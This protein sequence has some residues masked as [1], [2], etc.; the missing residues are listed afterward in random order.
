MNTVTAPPNRL[1]EIRESLGLSLND[2]ASLTG[3][4]PSTISRHE[5]GS[6]GLHS[7]ML[8]LYAERYSINKIEIFFREGSEG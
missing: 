1:R 2:A 7:E 5:T 6:R 3:L 8:S 4:S